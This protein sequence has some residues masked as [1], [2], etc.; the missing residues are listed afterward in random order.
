MVSK[1]L[2]VLYIRG[3]TF[4]VFNLGPKQPYFNSVYVVRVPIFSFKTVNSKLSE[5]ALDQR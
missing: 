1:K 5:E 4:K 2:Q 3:M